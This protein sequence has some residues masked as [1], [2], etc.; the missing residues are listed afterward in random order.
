MSVKVEGTESIVVF[1]Q[2]DLERKMAAI[3]AN[4]GWRT[5]AEF[6]AGVDAMTDGQVADMFR[7]LVKA[8]VDV[9]PL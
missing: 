9:V 8:L 4:K 1:S 5:N 6:K 2:L 7:R 3:C